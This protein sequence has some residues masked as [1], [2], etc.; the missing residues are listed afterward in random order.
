[1]GS[2]FSARQALWFSVINYAGVLI[3][4]FST[5]FIYPQ[6]RDLFGIF[7]YI[8]GYAQIFYPI[9]VLGASTALLNFYP[10]LSELHQRKLFSYSLI[11]IFWMVL[12]SAMGL[13]IIAVLIDFLNST[14]VLYAFV[15]AVFLAYV[16]LYKRQAMNLQKVAFPSFLEKIIPKIALPV[17]FLL[18]LY[19]TVSYTEGMLL[20][21]LS[22]LLMFTGTVLYVSRFYRPVLTFQFNDLFQNLSRKE[23]YR[24]SLY[25]FAASFGSYFAFRVDSL[26]ISE[27]TKSFDLNGIFAI[28]VNLANAL[29]IP[30]TGVFALYSP[31]IS[32]NIKHQNW[33][34]LKEKY[35]EV[36]KNLFFI[37]ILLY[38]CVLL[39]MNNLFQLL[40]GHDK[41]VD[42][43]PVIY[44]LGGSVVVN[45]AT[46]FST[47][48]IAYSRYYRFNLFAILVLAVVNVS[49]NFYILKATD[50]S[51]TG[52]AYA[53]FFS[54][55]LFNM[56]KMWFI[57]KKMNL[58]P[59]TGTYVKMGITAFSL[60][61]IFYFLPDFSDPFLNMVVKCG[62]YVGLFGAGALWGKWVLP[63]NH[64]LKKRM[65]L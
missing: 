52:V 4:T 50:W 44:I 42:S 27:L 31:I 23:Y 10:M 49:L 55:F 40:P 37:G 39:G 41:L 3:G 63:L 51:I 7:R 1:M 15:I 34:A 22:F 53:S 14:Y 36:A 43:L 17:L 20:Y 12:L 8:D 48:I 65:K 13:G 58:L 9:M 18:M 30:A 19:G 24:Y 62:G 38:G 57:H 16:D 26:M 45:M 59:F 33:G 46:G 32:E 35:A 28:G 54:M 61:G 56:M 64:F 29:M 47:E 2:R 21:V 5:L 11:S 60:L 25:A 6:N